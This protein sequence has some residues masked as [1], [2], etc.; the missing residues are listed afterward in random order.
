MSTIIMSVMRYLLC[1]RISRFYTRTLETRE[2]HLAKR[3]LVV[4]RDKQVLDA[5]LKARSLGIKV[6]MGLAEA[7]L[8]AE[9]GN[10][11][12]YRE[13]EYRDAQERWLN[14][15]AEYTD[16]V[17]P[18][19]MHRALL[20]LSRHPNP[21]NLADSLVLRLDGGRGGAGVTR[22]TA[23]AAAAEASMAQLIFDV[24]AS[25]LEFVK[26]Y[27]VM[28]LESLPLEVRDKLVF[29]GYETMGQV[30]SLSAAVL[31][32][33]FGELGDSI[34]ILA[35]GGGDAHVEDAYPPESV[36]DRLMFEGAVED[37]TM[38]DEAMQTLADRLSQ[39]LIEEDRQG[40]TLELLFDQEDGPPIARKRTFARSMQAETSLYAALIL[41][42]R[43][44]PVKSVV[45]IRVRMPPTIRTK[46]VQSAFGAYLDQRMR[47]TAAD[48]AIDRVKSV[49]G[50]ES[51]KT[52]AEMPTP[53]RKQLLRAYQDATGWV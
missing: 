52:G 35:R 33:Q 37:L 24:T 1:V 23:E 22:W 8:L 46:R 49:F 38:L 14:I 3:P 39:T 32:K 18:L 15:C 48:V 5:N 36:A 17:E 21:R 7:K 11:Y 12:A 25:S 16:F 9:G 50:D 20:D 47:T 34:R 43:D 45:G 53:R 30:A 26:R 10:F 44:I 6:G 42:M 4:H 41:M 40:K 19:D 13:D 28:Q 31:R 29:L 51:I 27:P 2:P